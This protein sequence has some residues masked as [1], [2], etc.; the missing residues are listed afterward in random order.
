M[1]RGTGPLGVSLA[2]GAAAA[3]RAIN[4]NWIYGTDIK[5]NLY[6]G[7]NKT[8]EKCDGNASKAGGPGQTSQ[9]SSTARRK[10][11]NGN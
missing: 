8:N 3:W 6:G 5:I 10:L 4:G 11:K 9:G 1:R 7:K 2:K